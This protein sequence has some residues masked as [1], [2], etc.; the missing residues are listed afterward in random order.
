MPVLHVIRAINGNE[1]LN[2]MDTQ[3]HAH[4]HAHGRT[5]AHTLRHTIKYG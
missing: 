5:H 1:T 4:S 3:S 2:K